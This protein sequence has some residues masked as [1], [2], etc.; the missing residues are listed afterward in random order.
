VHLIQVL[1]ADPNP[2]TC[3]EKQGHVPVS[4][5]ETPLV[6]RGEGRAIDKCEKYERE[7]TK[8]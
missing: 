6:V 5:D 4:T 1:E 7:L 3:T 2:T 8:L